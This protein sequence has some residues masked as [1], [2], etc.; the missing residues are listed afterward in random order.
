MT[1]DTTEKTTEEKHEQLEGIFKRN[2]GLLLITAFVLIDWGITMSILE[3]TLEAAI[4]DPVI[5]QYIGDP[6]IDVQ[7]FKNLLVL[8]S[9]FMY[10]AMEQLVKRIPDF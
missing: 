8:K 1:D 5:S 10:M 6:K 4:R 9:V 2:S 3:H 7:T